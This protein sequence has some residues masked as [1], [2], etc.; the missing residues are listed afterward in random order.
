M[1]YDIFPT[2]V[3]ELRTKTK[4]YPAET[5]GELYLLFEYMKKNFPKVEKPINLDGTKR[6]SAN[7]TRMVEGDI[8]INKI[9]SDLKLKKISIKF[10]NGSS[11]N[12]GANNRGNLFEPEFADA[13]FDWWE[14]GKVSNAAML[15]AIE[16]LEKEY[17]LSKN[18]QEL[19][20]DVVGGENTKRPLAYSPRIHITNP[21]GT[22]TNI[23]PAVTDITLY[24][25]K[26]KV[27]LSLKL[28]TTTTFFNVGVK[29]V[30]TKDD[31]QAY[32]IQGAGAQLL[33]LFGINHK[34]FCDIFNGRLKS[35]YVENAKINSTD[36]QHLLETGIGHGYHII[37]K[38]SGRILSKKMDEQA[39]KTAARVTTAKI[40]Y[41]GKGGNGK[42]VDI[43]MESATYKFKL[44]L[45]DTQG[46]DGYPTRLMCDFSYK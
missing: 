17:K 45:R 44:N 4:A 42:R 36:M 20:I 37:H 39:M 29:T 24:S 11:G 25:G 5:Q 13:L 35:G 10:G 31:I 15:T 9:K 2:S 1:A 16:S 18:S 30:L 33:N 34:T 32:N 21:A 8:T 3:Q 27:Y 28:G 38:L 6:N 7:V 23:G 22:G 43:E 46:K 12:R 26:K 14:G 19:G 41:G 40:Y